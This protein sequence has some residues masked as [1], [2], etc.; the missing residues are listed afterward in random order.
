MNPRI[1]IKRPEP[2]FCEPIEIRVAAVSSNGTGPFSKPL[3][4]DAPQPIVSPKLEVSELVYVSN[5]PNGGALF[6]DG[7]VEITFNFKAEE[8]TPGLQDLDVTPTLWL[9]KCEEPSLNQSKFLP[10]FKQG[11]DPG[12]VVVKKNI[13]LEDKDSNLSLNITFTPTLKENDTP[14]LYYK[15]FYGDAQPY[16][17]G[18]DTMDE[19]NLTHV[20][21]YAT[22]C[23]QFD[24]NGY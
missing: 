21:G 7:D 11:S 6:A 18:E 14:T 1:E 8:W 5:S 12:T 10:T 16:A 15:A 17:E 22:N 9:D 4:I 3:S 24:R 20:I 23:K 2:T 13:A 19:V